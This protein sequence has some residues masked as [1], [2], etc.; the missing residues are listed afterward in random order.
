MSPTVNDTGPLVYPTARSPR[1]DGMSVPSLVLYGSMSFPSAQVEPLDIERA[2]SWR[3]LTLPKVEALERA[4][5]ALGRIRDQVGV[6][7]LKGQLEDFALCQYNIQRCLSR[8]SLQSSVRGIIYE[9]ICEEFLFSPSRLW[10]NFSWKESMEI[11]IRNSGEPWCTKIKGQNL[12]VLTR[13]C[14]LSLPHS[15]SLILHGDACAKAQ[16]WTL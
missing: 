12:A 1:E 14:D 5:E 8:W 9:Q 10:R 15:L 6:W 4:W 11:Y 16:F 2:S 13:L 3:I 7:V